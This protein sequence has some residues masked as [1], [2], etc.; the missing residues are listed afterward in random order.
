[1]ILLFSSNKFDNYKGKKPLFYSDGS[2]VKIINAQKNW[3]WKNDDF[4][5]IMKIQELEFQNFAIKNQ[6]KKKM[7]NENLLGIKNYT[8]N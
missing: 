6:K 2:R 4:L 8:N 7:I 5:K 1:M 3:Y